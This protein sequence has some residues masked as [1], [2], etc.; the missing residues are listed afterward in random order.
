M[1]DRP[2]MA[3]L[4]ASE[5]VSH[6]LHAAALTATPEQEQADPAR[7]FEVNAVGTLNLLEAARAA[8]LERVVFVSSSGIYGPA[9]PTPLKRESDP[10]VID[11]LYAV[12]KQASEQLCRRYARLY[13]LVVVTGRLGTR[14]RPDGACH[15]L[16]PGHVADPPGGPRPPSR[17]GR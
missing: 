12:S 16:A 5:G 2:G 14:L 1:T 13:P 9:P 11:N 15:R 6:L 10:L 8:G 7:V 17:V 3:A 4:V